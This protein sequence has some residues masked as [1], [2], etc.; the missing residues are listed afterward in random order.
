MPTMR[1]AS[2]SSDPSKSSKVPPAKKHEEKDPFLTAEEAIN[3]HTFL[4][5]K[6]KSEILEVLE[7]CRLEQP[8]QADA[9]ELLIE[10]VT[11]VRMCHDALRGLSGGA[12]KD[13][14]D[15]LTHALVTLRR[16][17]TLLRNACYVLHLEEERKRLEERERQEKGKLKESH[18]KLKEINKEWK[19]GT[20]KPSSSKL[21]T[22]R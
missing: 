4:Q 22:R 14:T 17:K 3:K 13:P 12:N 16:Y 11:V 8:F 5:R 2:G 7:Q 15:E 10:V 6:E 1:R 19:K 21:T 20:D 9:E 18:G